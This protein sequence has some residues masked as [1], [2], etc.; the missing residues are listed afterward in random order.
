MREGDDEG[1][2]EEEEG[3]DE[4]EEEFESS[5]GRGTG[6]GEEDDEGDKPRLP[7]P[8]MAWGVLLWARSHVDLQYSAA[9]NGSRRLKM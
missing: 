3:E 7:M 4:Q 2:V 1:K 9:P 5:S 8:F 6:G